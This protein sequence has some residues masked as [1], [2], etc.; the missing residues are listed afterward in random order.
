MR[1]NVPATRN[2]GQT[3][4]STEAGQAH[5]RLTC[6]VQGTS[7]ASGSSRVLFTMDAIDRALTRTKG[8][9]V[10][11]LTYQG[12]SETLAKTVTGTTTT[13]YAHTGSGAP[14]AEKTGSTASFH[15]RDTHGD[16]V[17]LASTAAANQGTASF[18]PWGKGLATTGQSSFLGYQ[19]DMT[20][21][22]TKQVDMGTR[23]YEAGL[24]RFTARDV[25]FGE[26]TSPM[27]LNQHVYGGLN[28][29]TMW[30]PTGMGQCTMAGE[31]V[32]TTASGGSKAVGGNP[33]A[34]NHSYHDQASS[35]S[36]TP[37]PPAPEPLPPQ[38]PDRFQF[39]IDIVNL[40]IGAATDALE[41]YGAGATR[42]A[43][44]LFN[45]AGSG[46]R[47]GRVVESWIARSDAVYAAR[48][49]RSGA[50]RGLGFVAAG[51]DSIIRYNELRGEGRGRVESATI[52]GS[53]V[54]GGI[55]GAWAAA[56]AGVACGPFTPICSGIF[57]IGG[58][59][60]GSGLAETVVTSMFDSG[61]GC[62]D[63]V[64]ESGQCFYTTDID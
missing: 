57:A 52:S 15:L 20:D 25:I 58:G 28:P 8:S 49:G 42:E 31:C 37:R 4:L 40:A 45:G 16:V 54:A 14:L 18:D 51:V 60:I 59:F 3:N 27:T 17:G 55:G 35:V 38:D 61:E 12:I 11:S 9:D 29:I 24:G 53:R 48:F 63:M 2:S 39:P 64:G 13:T 34:A 22:D 30:D 33:G 23:W 44:Y 21:P 26:L 47:A 62:P 1:S 6:A 36:T 19:G 50:L 46:F 10:T 32:T 43:A 41:G 5:S 56:Q 7:C